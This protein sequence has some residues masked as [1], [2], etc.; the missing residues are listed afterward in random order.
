MPPGVL[1]RIL[2]LN[3]SQI[4]T[5]ALPNS[6]PPW[7]PFVRGVVGGWVQGGGGVPAP[8]PPSGAELLEVPKKLFGQARCNKPYMGL[9]VHFGSA[10][11]RRA[12]MYGHTFCRPNWPA[13]WTAVHSVGQIG[14][15][16]VR[17]DT[18][19]HPQTTTSCVHGQT[20]PYFG[21]LRSTDGSLRSTRGPDPAAPLNN[22]TPGHKP[23]CVCTTLCMYLV[24]CAPPCVCTAKSPLTSARF[25]Q[26]GG[27]PAQPP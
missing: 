26:R 21:S 10:Y 17:S 3:S 20:T 19:V 6:P 12:E 8:A 4:L 16:N 27:Q 24:V 18:S 2:E 9:G 23:P 1:R 22:K 7:P 13:A 15:P 11:I 25:A 5:A 14:R